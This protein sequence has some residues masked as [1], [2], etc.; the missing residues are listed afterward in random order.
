M[1]IIIPL[2]VLTGFAIG[3]CAGV[4]LSTMLRERD[5]AYDDD[6]R[7]LAFYDA[8]TAAQQQAKKPIKK[9][10]KKTK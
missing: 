2:A 1:T 4:S 9:S 10:T 6:N 7:M 3:C 8:V 5:V